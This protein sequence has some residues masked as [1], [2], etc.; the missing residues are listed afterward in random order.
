MADGDHL[1]H[2]QV[3]GPFYLCFN[4]DET[5]EDSDLYNFNFE[6]LCVDCVEIAASD[7]L[8]ENKDFSQKYFEKITADEKTLKHHLEYKGKLNE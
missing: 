5:F 1:E 4:C 2:P 8:E 7:L 3:L 6:W